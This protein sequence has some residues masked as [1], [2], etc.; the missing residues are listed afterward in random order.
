MP[1]SSAA[2]PSGA[3]SF[4]S[5]AG[6]LSRIPRKLE[7]SARDSS[8]GFRERVREELCSRGAADCWS[9][10]LKGNPRKGLYLASASLLG[11]CGSN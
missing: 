7:A 2:G 1:A 6:N 11:G 3:V 8:V 5:P 4:A 10:C 9:D